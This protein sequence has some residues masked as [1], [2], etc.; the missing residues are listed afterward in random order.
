MVGDKGP[1]ALEQRF[2]FLACEEAH[3]CSRVKSEFSNA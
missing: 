3:L 1:P 2:I